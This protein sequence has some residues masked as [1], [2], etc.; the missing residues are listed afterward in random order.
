MPPL[1]RS[2]M[3]CPLVCLTPR[4]RR[5]TQYNDRRYAAGAGHH[6]VVRPL[7]RRRSARH[8]CTRRW[9]RSASATTCCPAANCPRSCCSTAAVRLLPG[10]IRAR[11]GVPPRKAFPASFWNTRTTPA[12]PIGR[13]A[14]CPGCCCPAITPP[15][16]PGGRRR[17]DHRQNTRP[18]LFA[19]IHISHPRRAGSS[20]GEPRLKGSDGKMAS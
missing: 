1:H 16:P 17:P 13:G 12:R 20:P 15:S 4:G 11:R 19:S 8:R 7:R 14:A 10:V 3:S 2:P 5:L 6:P 9:R 18:D